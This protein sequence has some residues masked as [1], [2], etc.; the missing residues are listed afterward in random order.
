MNS[1]HHLLDIITTDSSG[2]GGAADASGRMASNSTSASFPTPNRHTIIGTNDV[3][4]GHCGGGGM[5]GMLSPHP[6][7]SSDQHLGGRSLAA[8]FLGLN[9]GRSHTAAPETWEYGKQHLP[10]STKSA[11]A[12]SSSNAESE[13]G[14]FGS[15]NQQQ[16]QQHHF[17]HRD[18]FDDDYDDDDREAF[19]RLGTRR[20]ASTGVIGRQNNGAY[21]DNSGDVNSI[22]ETLGITSL[23][24]SPD[25]N[26]HHH[27]ISNGISVGELDVSSDSFV[28]GA[29]IPSNRSLIMEKIIRERDRD[30][31][32]V[33]THL[34]SGEGDLSSSTV[35]SYQSSGSS[36]IGLQY[37]AGN[38]HQQQ[39][40]M[41][42]G[43][44]QVHTNQYVL[45][46]Q[47]LPRH[48]DSSPYNFQQQQ[49]NYH[50][51]QQASPQAYHSTDYRSKYPANVNAMQSNVLQM[52]AGQQHSHHQHHQQ[53]TVYHINS[54]TAAPYS[55]EYQTSQQQ[56]QQ[57][58][59]SMP[60]NHILLPHQ[61]I[62]GST[63]PMHGQPQYISIVPIQAVAAHS[64]GGGGQPTYAYVQYGDGTMAVTSP[65]NL[66]AGGG[67]GGIPATTFVMSPNGPIAVSSTTPSGAVPVNV[68]NF[69][70]HHGTSSSA[71][72]SG[73]RSPTRLAVGGGNT[74]KSPDRSILCQG[75]NTKKNILSSPR[76]GKRVDKNATIPSKLGPEASYLLNEIRGAKSRNMWTIH[77]IRGHV[78][79]FCNDQNGSRFIQQRLEVADVDEKNAVMEEVIPAMKELQN[80]VFGNYVI[81]KL[82]EFGTD[83]MKKELKGALTG[84]MVLLSLQMHG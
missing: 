48:Q 65:P 37:G 8:E 74:L 53:Q 13:N 71:G 67:G 41:H 73:L 29:H 77:D 80:D 69:S 59:G 68:F 62:S 83:S 57:Q 72:S 34:Q 63:A 46:E 30:P 18:F 19:M 7:R 31:S 47:S 1:N 45:Q 20:P 15:S 78:V 76:G 54:P 10:S 81:Q 75:K 42:Q 64:I 32:E 6:P 17:N 24:P 28:K 2:G 3:G 51:Q 12:L 60:T 61:Q 52:N 33:P 82:F 21:H 38:H 11:T 35:F 40:R 25:K 27:I 84:N 14:I 66:V 4:V 50:H 79:E 49:V 5:S 22:L 55:L 23:E 26:Q 9:L 56:Q 36:Q 44:S 58:H 39:H 43:S 70:G 16:Q